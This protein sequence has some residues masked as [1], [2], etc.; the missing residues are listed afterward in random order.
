M[1]NSTIQTDKN[2]S[3]VQLH[4][5]LC[6]MSDTWM[7]IGKEEIEGSLYREFKLIFPSAYE[8]ASSHA[9]AYREAIEHLLAK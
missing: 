6:Q 3:P 9:E 7:I 4:Y 2:P 5:M 1:A 8:A